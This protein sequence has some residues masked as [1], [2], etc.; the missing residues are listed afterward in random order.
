MTIY[1]RINQL[2]KDQK[3]TRKMLCEHTGISYHTLTSL[4]Q[5]QS[6]NMNL[7][8]I[9]N[10]ANYLGVSSEYLISGNKPNNHVLKDDAQIPVE[11]RLA[12]IDREIIRMVGKLSIKSK[13]LLLAKAYELE[14][15]EEK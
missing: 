10:I 9:T 14:E 11:Y 6:Q 2:L 8:T 1:D 12:E 15:D 7:N 4:F 5:R 13:T 3:K